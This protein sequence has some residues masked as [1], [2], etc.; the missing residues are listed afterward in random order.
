MKNLANWLK[1]V[2]YLAGEIYKDAAV[3]FEDNPVLRD[4]MKHLSDDETLHYQIMGS[5]EDYFSKVDVP[6]EISIDDDTKRRIEG[7]FDKLRELM[8]EGKLNDEE[9]LKSVIRIEFSEWNKVFVYVVSK[10]KH[11]NYEFS[12]D[13][14]EFQR[15]INYI[16]RYLSSYGKNPGMLAEIRNI[17]TV[18]KQKILVVEDVSPLAEFL[19]AL[20]TAEGEVDVAENGEEALAMIKKSFYNLVISDLKMPVMDGMELFRRIEAEHPE[21]TGLFIFHATD[22]PLEISAF[23]KERSIPLLIKPSSIDII[24]KTVRSTLKRN[25]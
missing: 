25:S 14:S 7:G 12:C 18:W 2:E 4:F 13:I 6:A 19:K 20:L 5:A 23:A 22:P 1:K 21:L 16:E 17:P 10:L 15:H 8:N 24:L 9:M 11:N 3:Y